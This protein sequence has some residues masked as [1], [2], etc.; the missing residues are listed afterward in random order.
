MLR[1]EPSSGLGG[2][3]PG[4][5]PVLLAVLGMAWAEMQPLQLQEEQAPMPGGKGPCVRTLMEE[6]RALQRQS[7]GLLE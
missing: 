3:R 7:R 6:L 4:L 5:L 2:H 1:L